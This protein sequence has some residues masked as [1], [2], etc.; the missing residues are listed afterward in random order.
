MP[1]AS[2]R[3]AEI[4]DVVPGKAFKDLLG[5][6]RRSLGYV[7]VTDD[8]GEYHTFMN[9]SFNAV[10]EPEVGAKGAIEYVSSGTISLWFWRPE[11]K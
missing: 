4:T 10:I 1:K 9:G 3:N 6:P 5:H 2:R 8:T 11:V 7:G